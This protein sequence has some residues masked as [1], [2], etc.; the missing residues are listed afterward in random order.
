[1]GTTFEIAKIVLAV[2]SIPLTVIGVL[3]KRSENARDIKLD[4]MQ[5]EIERN[6]TDL[7]EQGK[8]IIRLQESKMERMQIEEMLD[9]RIQPLSDQIKT[10]NETM[11]KV[12]DVLI[13]SKDDR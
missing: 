11:N 9:R 1:M 6:E 8:D 4:N 2:L 13:K 7:K 5:K 3:W 12:L 10:V